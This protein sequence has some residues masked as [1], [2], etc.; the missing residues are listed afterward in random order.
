[1]EPLVFKLVELDEELQQEKQAVIAQLK[2]NQRVIDFL[3]KYKLNSSYVEEFPYRFKTWIDSKDQCAYCAGLENCNQETNGVHLDLIYDGN[4]EYVYKPCPYQLEANEKLAHV[5]NYKRNHLPLHLQSVLF[6]DIDIK[7]EKVAYL[8]VFK[9]I[10]SWYKQPTSKGF[11]LWGNVGVGKTYLLACLS[12]TLAK[13]GNKV[14]FIHVPTF[15]LEMKNL[16]YDNEEF[17][18]R[19]T[20]LMEVPYLFFDDIGAENAT[21]WIR[22]ELLLPI[23]EYRMHNGGITMFTSNLNFEMLHDHYVLNAHGHEE[24]LKA[25]RFLERVRFLA[26]EVELIGLNRR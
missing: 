14:A 7:K 15:I 2:K 13:E 24:T 8:Q 1:M 5:K 20:E 10:V 26:K 11:Y 22:D 6:Q 12:N 17:Q 3:K 19:I 21:P 23:L 9:D 16:F 25:T 4:L 18:R